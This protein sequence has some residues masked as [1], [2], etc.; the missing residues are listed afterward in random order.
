MTVHRTERAVIIGAGVGGLTTALLLAARG[1][2]VTVLERAAA[3]GGKMRQVHAGGGPIDAGPTV[4][5]MRWVFEDIFAETGTSLDT[6]LTLHP[7]STLARH[8]W[9]ENTRLDLF[10]DIDQS[11]DAIGAF[12]GTADAAGYRKFCARAQAIHDSLKKPFLE[13]PQPGSPLAL[14]RRAGVADMLKIAAFSTL[15]GA[16]GGYFKDPRLRQMFA[17]YATY[18]GSSPYL[19]PATL[20]LIAHVERS[21]VWLIEGGMHRLAQVLA[22]RAIALG[23]SIRYNAHVEDIGLANG[24]ASHVR[25]AG[26]ERIDADAIVVNADCAALAT[27]RFGAAAA[28]AVP[29]IPPSTRSLSALTWATCANVADFPL[30]H[31]TVFFG[32]AYRQE[33]T[34][35]FGRNKL[36][37]TTPTIYI[38]AQDRDAAGHVPPGPERLLILVNAPPHGDTKPPT[39][40]DIELCT[41]K[42][43]RHL[44]ACGL[45]LTPNAQTV[46]TGPAQFNTLFPATGGALYGQATHGT[47]ASF[48]R[49]PA[50]TRIPGLYLAGGSAH[51]GAGVPMAALSGRLAA[52]A[53]MDG[54]ASTRMS[55]T[56]AISGG[57]SMRS[58]MTGSTA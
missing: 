38:C 36:P 3:P 11:V 43:F 54:L 35:I 13:S 8:A 47:M 10:A 23:A 21:G 33:F 17:R 2:D 20:M 31:H 32:D 25:L 39:P 56:T 34:D 29:A 42:S 46:L 22:E 41:E 27:G 15:W 58:A 30:H 57:T 1:L 18:S 9:N 24:R 51:P 28:R 19:A 7:L 12:A 48:R 50:T 14:V 44:A 40:K 49:P 55:R 45:K 53:V 37:T 6:H 5:T 16:L 26:G 52:A 4:F